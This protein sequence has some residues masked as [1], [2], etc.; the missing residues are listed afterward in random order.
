M[1]NGAT[2][3]RD[4]DRARN[5]SE[6]RISQASEADLS[7]PLPMSAL[8][9][10]THLGSQTPLPHKRTCLRTTALRRTASCTIERS[11]DLE[12]KCGPITGN[13]TCSIAIPTY[14]PPGLHP[15]L[16]AN[17]PDRTCLLGKLSY[18]PARFAFSRP[19]VVCKS[20]IRLIWC[21]KM[22]QI[23]AAHRG[24]YVS[25]IRVSTKKQ[26]QSGLGLKAQR[27]AVEAWLNGGNWELVKE[28]VE[29]ES[30]KSDRNRPEL[31][32]ALDT[33]RRYRAKLIISRLDRL[34]RDP[35]FLL[36]LRDAGIDFVALDMPN[37]NRM[38]VGIMAMVAE[39]EREVLS[40]RTRD[41][42]AAKKAQGVKLGN[43]RPET[44][45]FNDRRTARAAAKKAGA[46]VRKQ[47]DEFAALILPLLDGELAGL[48]NNAAAG[49]LN[50]RGVK[51]AR[52]G[53]WTARSVLNLKARM[54]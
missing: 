1:R 48:S 32:Q 14:P 36:S 52:G 44:L 33:C 10:T 40:Q 50:S 42:L 3:W 15:T 6:S 9:P 31:Q 54:S 43:P 47:A 13:D 21:F 20:P 34:S 29:I 53:R 51:T 7:G 18:Q 37:A 19:N 17:L 2:T 8:G 12:R 41:A 11:T 4:H 27:A 22:E 28:I 49:E 38:T 35:V 46:A 16:L 26:Q 30:G 39:Q 23:V 45:T 5:V 24:K 25:Y